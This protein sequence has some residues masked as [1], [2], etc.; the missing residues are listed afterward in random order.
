MAAFSRTWLDGI[1][2]YW[3]WSLVLIMLLISTLITLLSAATF[4]FM[5]FQES[6][7]LSV[8]I[9]LGVSIF[10]IFMATYS[11]VYYGSEVRKYLIRRKLI[12]F[13]VR[14]SFGMV[15]SQ[16]LVCS[17]EQLPG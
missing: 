13:D 5:E 3:S 4:S 10:S 8:S 6:S 17:P 14:S 1:E 11:I 2:L 7:Q 15:P 9:G 12:L 16:R